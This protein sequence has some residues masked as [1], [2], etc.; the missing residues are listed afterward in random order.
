MRTDFSFRTFFCYELFIS[1]V[2][3]NNYSL[4]KLSFILHVAP[5]DLV[6]SIVPNFISDVL[7]SRPRDA[8]KRLWQLIGSNLSIMEEHLCV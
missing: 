7:R 1:I 4:S 8:S 6:R 5:L 2:H 3:V